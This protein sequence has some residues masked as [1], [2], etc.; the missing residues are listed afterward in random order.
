MSCRSKKFVEVIEEA[1]ESSK[2]LHALEEWDLST[3]TEDT[4]DINECICGAPLVNKFTLQNRLN[5]VTL[6]VG[7]ECI[8]KFNNEAMNAAVILHIK[9]S[10]GNESGKRLCQS[11]C[12]YRITDQELWRTVCNSCWKDGSREAS[13][14]Y[15]L[16]LGQACTECKGKFIPKF[17]GATTCASCYKAKMETGQDCPRCKENKLT[18]QQ[19]MC[20]KCSKDCTRK[21][22]AC[23]ASCI[24]GNSPDY[25]KICDSCSDKEPPCEQCGI[26]FRVFWKGAKICKDCREGMISMARECFNCGL[27]TIMP[28]EPSSTSVCK[29]CAKSEAMRACEKCKEKKINPNSPQFV[30]VCNDCQNKALL[31]KGIKPVKCKTVNCNGLIPPA[32]A[33]Y[34]NVCSK[35]YFAG[36]R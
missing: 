11:C 4:R 30:T 15:L 16:A 32:D 33:K 10:K 9:S 23:H 2:Y 5:K 12:D 3:H 34:K 26:K 36:K 18:G 29:K 35:C 28:N 6:V 21:C 25:I 19:K 24:Y 31:A 17:E 13:E 14:T 27:N 22:E 1:S 8:S 7:G 20:S